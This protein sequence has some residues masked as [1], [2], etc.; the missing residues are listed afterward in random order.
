M[1]S[2]LVTGAGGQ[3]GSELTPA[4]RERYGQ[5]AVIA[6]GPVEVDD[7]SAPFEVL[8]VTD[9]QRLEAVVTEYD[10]D[11]IY[12][13]AAILSAKGEQDPQLTYQ[14][15]VNGL[16]NVLEVARRQDLSQVIVPSTIAVFGS[17]TPDHP[18][19]KTVLRPTTMY[20][21][22][23]VF[24][25]LLASYYY[26]RFDLDV[27]GVRL[28][29]ILSYKTPPG[30]GT[31]DYAVEVF[32]EA[33]ESGSYTYFVR[34]DTQLPMMYM[35]DAIT[36]LLQLADA[37]DDDLS[38][39]CEYNV[40][41]LEF[42]PRELTAAIREHIPDFEAHYEPDDR[43][44]IADSWPNT[45]DDSAAREDWGWSPAYGLEAMV[46]DMVINLRQKLDT[47]A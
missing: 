6:S 20:G 32:Y 5:S 7:P 11:T 14:V 13:L 34:E 19:E 37:D 42:T 30:G 1:S 24:L 16:Y 2:I 4:L 39:R 3:I 27:R 28:P 8:D 21:I 35:P 43:Q 29:G 46:E 18:G 25:E 33:I 12:H 26:R 44:E 15:N 23:K 40:G 9:E 38:Y 36:A 45:I 17:D 10:V 31:T 41:A 22:S 47:P